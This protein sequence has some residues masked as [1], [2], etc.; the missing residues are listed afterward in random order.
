ML[1]CRQKR[2]GWLARLSSGWLLLLGL[3][4]CNNSDDWSH[5]PPP[6]MGSIIVDNLTR[7]GVNV[8]LDGAYVNSVDDFDNE[9]YDLEPGM[10]RVVL[11]ESH[12]SCNWRDDVDVIEGKLTI[13]EVKTGYYESD[14]DVRTYFD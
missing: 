14:Y 10:Y 1:S 8:Y 11:D 5:T 13:L 3:C 6:G 4:A 7:D 12:G 2:L 9:V